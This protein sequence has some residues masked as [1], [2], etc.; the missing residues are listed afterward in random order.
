MA[1][2]SRV[3]ERIGIKDVF[4]PTEFLAMTSTVIKKAFEPVARSGNK[5]RKEQEEQDAHHANTNRL[6]RYSKRIADR[7]CRVYVRF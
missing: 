3:L 4:D 5:R 2:V 7:Q 6:A 1:W